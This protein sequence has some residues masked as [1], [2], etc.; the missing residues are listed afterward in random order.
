MVHGGPCLRT[1]GTGNTGACLR[2]RRAPEPG[3]FGAACRLPQ[4]PQI[5]LRL[6]RVDYRCNRLLFY[7]YGDFPRAQD[8]TDHNNINVN[9]FINGD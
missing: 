4:L 8:D 5:Q 9:N 2:P 3:K 1:P 7:H 6:P